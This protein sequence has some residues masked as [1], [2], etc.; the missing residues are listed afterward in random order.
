MKF[1][2]ILHTLFLILKGILREKL[3]SK[4]FGINKQINKLVKTL[5]KKLVK[6]L[7]KRKSRYQFSRK[8]S[9]KIERL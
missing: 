7:L 6:T 2:D 1:V 8:I 4:V 3:V 9:S 5:L